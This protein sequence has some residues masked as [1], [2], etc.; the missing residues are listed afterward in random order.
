[1]EH[2]LEEV[3]PV[4]TRTVLDRTAGLLEVACVVT[5]TIVVWRVVLGWDWSSVLVSGVETTP[6]TGVDWTVL[7]IVAMLGVGWL[8]FRGRAVLGTVLVCVPVIV[9]SGWR[10]AVGGVI[11]WPTGL[12]SLVFS[13]SAT[14]MITAMIGAWVRYR[15]GIR[16]S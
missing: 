8:A 10:M 12:A 14:C 16:R 7:G 11:G 15:A 1:M 2:I 3:T 5:F 4:R 6:Q 13:L 9:L